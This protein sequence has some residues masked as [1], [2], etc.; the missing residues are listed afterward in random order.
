[1]TLLRKSRRSTVTG[2]GRVGLLALI[3]ALVFATACSSDSDGDSDS[4]SET[5]VSFPSNPATGSPLKIGVINP[6]GGPAIS[7]PT[8][9][10]AAEAAAKYANESLGGIAG[11]PVEIVYCANKEDPA[12]ARDCANQMV[13]QGVAGVVVPSTG[14]GSAMVPIIAGAGIPYMSPSGASPAELTTP[15]AFM[16]TGGFPGVLKG[17]ADY[18]KAEGFKNVTI[19]VTDNAS[20]VPA[21]K[22]MGQPAFDAA[23]V[24]LKIVPIPLGTPDTTPQVSSGLSDKPEAVGV[25]GDAT[26]CTSVL[27][28]MT[29]LA[30]TQEKMLIQPCTDPSTV[31]AVGTAM[32]GAKIFTTADT[33]SD[34]PEAVLYRNVMA[35]YAPDTDIAGY[36]YTGYQTMLGFIR[37]AQGVQ[38]DPTP[39]SIAAAIA[40]AKN[41][42]LPAGHEITFTC[43]GTALPSMK[44]VC[45]SKLIAA[46]IEDG[47]QTSAEVVG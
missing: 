31:E 14:Q 26:V 11:H 25:V 33:V 29:N 3:P 39:Q 15:N 8:N 28:A 37:A 42:L 24:A 30:A 41:V 43:D 1:M 36:T 6:E 23:G 18:S 22:A 12:S 20:V 5:S 9:R 4:G 13:E 19:Y 2:V 7:Q 35:T 32:D 47:T 16:L 10:E 40:S 21:A 17:M 46:T 27:K 34:D 38:G 44:S 45:S